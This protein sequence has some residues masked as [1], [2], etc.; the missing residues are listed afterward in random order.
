[1]SRI[2][3]GGKSSSIINLALACL[4][5]GM[6]ACGGGGGGSDS[7]DGTPPAATT[8]NGS[9]NTTTTSP[10]TSTATNAATLF[11]TNGTST[12]ERYTVSSAGVLTKQGSAPLCSG[13]AVNND[14]YYEPSLGLSSDGIHLYSIAYLN[15][16]VCEYAVNSDGSMAQLNPPASIA[17]ADQ[18]TLISNPAANNLV[19]YSLN[20]TFN[21]YSVGSNGQLTRNSKATI[22]SLTNNTAAPGVYA[23]TYAPGGKSLY[24]VLEMHASLNGIIMYQP[25][26]YTFNV[27]ADGTLTLSTA[28]P[29]ALSTSATFSSSVQPRSITVK[30]DGT[31]LYVVD[32]AG[33]VFQF[34]VNTGVITPLT[35]PMI[36]LASTGL[37]DLL[38]TPSGKSAFVTDYKSKRIWQ[39]KVGTDGSLSTASPTTV[40]VCSETLEKL[41]IAVMDTASATLYLGCT[42]GGI[43]HV[44]V[45]AASD[46]GTLTLQK[47][48]QLNTNVLS[49]VYGQI[50]GMAVGH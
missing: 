44:V 49:S 22:G 24:A 41:N 15:N 11:L 10:T 39:Y 18:T 38:I 2:F 50:N 42:N 14:D 21:Q 28:Q 8:S 5:T 20:S 7:K 45:Y 35:T 37:G 1:M 17:D 9:N 36:S 3:K 12:V 32:T 26:I 25:A 30:P 27:G 40:S 48:N 13:I 34:S 31:A 19:T 46:T 29:V 33:H 4:V 16:Q 6:S 47:D 23:A 43:G